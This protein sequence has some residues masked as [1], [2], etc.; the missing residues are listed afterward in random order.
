MLLQRRGHRTLAGVMPSQLLLSVD[1]ELEPALEPA[2]E[3]D[4]ELGLVVAAWWSLWEWAP[5][6]PK[7]AQP[8]LLP[9]MATATATP[10]LT[11]LTP[12]HRDPTKVHVLALQQRRQQSL[13]VMASVHEQQSACPPTPL[14]HR[15]P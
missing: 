4:L 12:S 6:E 11:P 3:L 15:Q 8:C 14:R 13:L 2:V 1:L 10:T 9:T 5:R 7:L